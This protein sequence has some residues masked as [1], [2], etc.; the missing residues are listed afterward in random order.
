[1]PTQ[2]DQ[3]PSQKG[4][5]PDN[6]KTENLAPHTADATGEFMTT[7]HGVKINDDQNS[8]KA[9]DRGPSLL[10][11]F[12]LRE[13]ITHFDHERIPERIV[14]ARG[15]AAHG[16]FQ[17]YESQ[18]DITRAG[19]L[20]DTN[21]QTPV[22]V[23]FSTVAG[24]RGSTD[25]A[26][27]VRGFA[28]KFYTQ[29]GNFDLVGNNMPVFFIQDAMKFPDLVHAVKPEPDNEI[30]QAASAHDTFWDFISLMPESAHMIMWTMS[31]RAI[32]R[33]YRMMEGFGVH[34]FRMINA[35]GKSSFVKF[36]WKPLLGVHSVAWDEAQK[37]SGKDPDYHRR[38]L[39]E[40]IESGN[41]PEWE[42]GLQIIPEEDEHKY[43]FDLLDPT[44]LVPEELVPVK[45][46]GKLTLNRNPDNF[47]AETEQVAFHV[48]NIIPGIDFTNDPLMQGRLFSYTDTQLIRLGGPNFHEIP[49]NRPVVPVHNNQRD[50]FMRQ[51]I[52]KGKVSY[53]PNSLGGGCPF[54]AGK[55]DGGFVSHNERIDAHKIRQRSASFFDHFS[56]AKLFFNSQS[57]PEKAHIIDALSFELGKVK[58]IAVR[59]RMLHIL[60]QIDNGLATA[61]AYAL[62]LHIPKDETEPLNQSIPADGNPVDFQPILK[63]SSLATSPALSMANTIKD[64]IRTRKIAI[65]LA[66]GVDDPSLNGIT[67]ALADAGAIVD[68]I[69][70]RQGVVISEGDMQ[71]PIGKSLLTEASVFYDAVYV[72]GGINN[73]ATLAADPDAVHFLNE[74]F[75]HC[76]AIGG[77]QDAI[78]VFTE[79]YFGKKLPNS[80]DRETMLEE[81]IVIGS[82]N[83]VAAEL[84]INSVSKHR[85]WEREKSR[86]VPA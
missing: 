40:A 72:P 50:G 77:H 47:F 61:V 27:D 86:K 48:G 46:I 82:D 34:T 23:R 7:D 81:G 25:L 71:I 59:E 60:W 28:V 79:T 49:I 51:S 62:G 16:V 37:I 31:D 2:K 70:P 33:S 43:E 67:S 56:Q 64:N 80:D 83:E 74:A 66:D 54:Q 84:F 3:E 76:K 57:E 18:A 58:T 78:Q 19:F 39:W 10:E 45:K 41:F 52:N 9:G 55:L 11:D 4:A 13:K 24:S 44:K 30:P 35:G 8:L 65:L 85:F 12:I 5:Q 53:N 21:I 14:H 73:V 75:R 63:E 17:L 38:D 42:L 68:L 69:A 32:P 29:E 20:N 15:A 6:A 1:M 36:H 22:F 26:R